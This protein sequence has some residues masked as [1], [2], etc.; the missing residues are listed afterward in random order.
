MENIDI[1]KQRK[2]MIRKITANCLNI[3]LIICFILTLTGCIPETQAT[4]RKIARAAYGGTSAS[5]EEFTGDPI[6]IATTKSIAFIPFDYVGRL[7]GFDTMTFTT[8]F[9]S[10]MATQGEVKVVFPREAM[11]LVEI[12][13]RKVNSH[14]TM[15]AERVMMGENLNNLPR[16]ERSRARK[17]N[18][19][20]S[21][22]D[23]VKIGRM[24]KVDAVVTGTVSDW[25][26]Y[27]RPR[28]CVNVKIIATGNSD[29][30]AQALAQMTQWG[31]PR[32]ASTARGIIWFMQ[33]NFDSRDSDIGRNVWAYGL[34]KHTEEKAADIETYLRSISQYY[35]YVGSVLSR[36]VLQ[37]REDAIE[38]AEK[39]ALEEAQKAQL[40][41][42]GVRNKLRA[43]TDPYYQVPNAQAVMNQ[44]LKDNRDMGWRPDVYNLQHQ[45]KKRLINTY[46]DPKLVAEQTT[47]IER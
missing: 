35:D 17:I 20:I 1:F 28:M 21:L 34:T 8:R 24:L 27:M 40:A 19:V 38:E 33:Q 22:D 9:A 16:D 10:Q 31:V 47:G 7:E 3:L 11:K 45:D 26:P 6:A 2:I 13:N 30:A 39:R 4:A 15:L 5:Y 14:N 37:T 25:N 23:A 18:P 29:T 44:T 41:Q 46:V 36:A 43:L 32:Q 42:A 12:E